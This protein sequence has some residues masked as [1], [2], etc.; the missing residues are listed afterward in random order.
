MTE[1]LPFPTIPNVPA[2]EHLR[3]ALQKNFDAL[4]QKF[5]VGLTQAQKELFLQL[6]V[7][8]SHKVAFG[9]AVVEYPGGAEEATVKEVTHG[10]G[11]EPKSVT[12]T[13]KINAA[14]HETVTTGNYSETSFKLRLFSPGFK[15]PKENRE[16]AWQAIS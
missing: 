15:P 3:E 9:I 5:P 12:A 10:L 4:A 1:R 13:I 7:P 16:V 8:G 6:A 2:D 11:A 14:L